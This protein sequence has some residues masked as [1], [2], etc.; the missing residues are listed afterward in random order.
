MLFAVLALSA[1]LLMSRLAALPGPVALTDRRV[2]ALGV[3][4]GLAALTRNEAIWLGFIW[5]L[6]AWRAGTAARSWWRSARSPCSCSR[7][8]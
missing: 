6:I 4:I 3:V 5:L 7:R 8:G 2:I 1:C